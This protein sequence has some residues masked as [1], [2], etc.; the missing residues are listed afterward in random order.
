MMR[1]THILTLPLATLFVS[2]LLS[3]CTTPPVEH[4]Y[5]L[6]YP[7]AST[8]QAE[9]Q[10]EL[11]IATVK[12]PEAINRPQLVIQKSA[13][14]SLVTDEQRWIAPLD[15]QLTLSLMA[16]LRTNLPDAWL[17]SD[18]GISAG[19]AT[20]PSSPLPRYLAKVQIDQ[21]LINSG[22]QLTLE[23]SWVVLDHNRKLLKREHNIFTVRLNGSAY[24]A[25]APA[26]SEAARQLAE[27]VGTSVQGVR[28]TPATKP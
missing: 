11:V 7:L 6:D 5:R 16:H 20:N 2:S 10:Y 12:V 14:E 8:T 13:T 25:V 15:E 3:A 9:P 26:M 4:L 28:K 22:S 21:L 18:T 27:Q 19:I 23:A 1:S 24:E 17:S